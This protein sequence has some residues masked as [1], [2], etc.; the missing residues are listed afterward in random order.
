[1]VFEQILYYKITQKHTN[2]NKH[3]KARLPYIQRKK[4]G[5][6]LE[7]VCPSTLFKDIQT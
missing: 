2:K 4:H 1:M 3:E 7:L 6:L 5:R